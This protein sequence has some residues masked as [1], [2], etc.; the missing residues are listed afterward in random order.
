MRFFNECK[1]GWR[2][3]LNICGGSQ[4]P[5]GQKSETFIVQWNPARVATWM[6][7]SFKWI[8]MNSWSQVPMVC[9][10]RVWVRSSRRDL[11]WFPLLNCGEVAPSHAAP[12]GFFVPVLVSLRNA[13]HKLRYL[14]TWSLFGGAT[15]RGLGG[16]ALLEEIRHCGQALRV[17][18]FVLLPVPSLCFSRLSAPP[19]MPA[20]CHVLRPQQALLCLKL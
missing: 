13:P 6:R 12:T 16:V 15:W 20:C 9:P 5:T 8:K 17:Y 19:T 3:S 1:M 2:P 11:L 18:S 14:N 4:M 10:R 7:E